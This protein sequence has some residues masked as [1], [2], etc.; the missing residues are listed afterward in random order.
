MTTLHHRRTRRLRASTA[1]VFTAA[2]LAAGAAQAKPLQVYLTGSAADVTPA[3]HGPAFDLAGGSTDVDEAFQ[4]TI[5]RIRG[6]TGSTCAAKI[7]IVVL[8]S[9]GAD[10]YNDY[11]YAMN[12]VDS[13]ETIIV[14]RLSDASDPAIVQRVANAEF[15]FFAG[16]DQCDYVTYF[17]GT[18]I[19]TAVASVY[20]RRGAVGGTSAGL[21]IQGEYSYDACRSPF[22]VTSEAALTNP[23][24][25]EIT[26]TF[27]FLR[28]PLLARVIT[29]SHFVARDRMGRLM[30]FLARQLADGVTNE[31]WGLGVNE[32]TSLL[33]DA[34]GNA[35]VVGDGPVYV[36]LADHSPITCAPKQPLRYTGYKLWKYSAGETFSLAEA[37]R[38]RNGFY[39]VDAAD[40]ALSA[41]PY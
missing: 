13:V 7:D 4:Q 24:D 22:G 19:A 37:G 9:S 27:D 28:W 38:P 3:L 15:V 33:V 5:D 17:K 8:R 31:A 39:T 12:G 14:S 1:L 35:T 18:P 36:V 20:A 29:D 21:A 23:Y 34:A 6:C 16:G 10:G 2:A 11:L 41:N 32:G 25:K 40:G 30:T 26:F